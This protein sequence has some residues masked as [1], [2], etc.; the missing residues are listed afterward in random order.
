MSGIL[1]AATL[2]DADPR[3]AAG[4]NQPKHFEFTIR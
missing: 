2:T 1:R 3:T 4:A